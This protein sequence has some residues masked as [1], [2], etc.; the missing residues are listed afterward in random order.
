LMA[1]KNTEVFQVWALRLSLAT[2]IIVV[3]LSWINAVRIFDLIVRAGISFGV[4]YLLTAGILSLFERTASAPPQESHSN[5][6]SERGVLLDVA[7]GDDELLRSQVQDE[8]FPPGQVDP[9]L[10][11]GLPDSERQAEIVRRMGWGDEAE[12]E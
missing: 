6:V 11:T 1:V 10:S 4:M 7:V 5:A 12:K 2:T 3:L 9:R 8:R